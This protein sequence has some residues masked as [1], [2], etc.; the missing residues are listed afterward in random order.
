MLDSKESRLVALALLAL[1][2]VP[3]VGAAAAAK[4][5]AKAELIAENT[6]F[7]P[8]VN[9]VALRLTPDPGWHVYW[10]NPGDSGQTT[11]VEWSLPPGAAAGP[12]AWPAPH[13]FRFGALVSYGYSEEVLHLVPITLPADAAGQVAVEAEARW[14]VCADACIPGKASLALELPVAAKPQADSRSAAAFAQARASLPRT[15]SRQQARFAVAD[16]KLVLTIE[17]APAA[18]KAEFFAEPNDLVDHS[19][20]QKLAFAEGA[21]RLEQPLSPYFSGDTA[22]VRGVLVLHRGAAAEAWQIAARPASIPK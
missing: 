20:P 2:A 5:H 13:S 14:L 12:I 17:G 21:W 4:E 18:D 7:G 8:G 3:P 9:W 19:A 22:E 16:E 1:A 10:I 6:S 11:T 15:D